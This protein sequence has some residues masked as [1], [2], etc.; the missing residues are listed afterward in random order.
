MVE[1]AQIV[2]NFVKRALLLQPI[3][4]LALLDT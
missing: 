2:V 4:S 1:Y 3:A